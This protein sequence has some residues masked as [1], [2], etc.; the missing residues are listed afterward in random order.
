MPQIIP[1]AFGLAA[2]GLK[3]A[4]AWIVFGLSVVSGALIS[5]REQPQLGDVSDIGTDS[6]VNT[7]STQEPLRIIYGQLK[8]GGNDVYM[9][10]DGAN[11]QDLWIVQSLSE[12]ECEGVYAKEEVDQVYLDGK[13]YTDFGGNVT[14][15]FHSGTITQS[16]DTNL[17][18]ALTEWTDPL[19]NTCYMVWKLTNDKD[20]F[21]GLPSRQIELRG[22]KLYDFRSA[23]TA[24]SNNPVLAIYDYMTNTRYGMGVASAD[25]DTTSWTSAANYCDTKGWTLNM[26][27]KRNQP[28]QYVVDSMLLHFRY[29]L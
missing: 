26:V 3:G 27:I 24:Y 4:A 18:S 14:Y 13:I 21:Q 5:S 8:V 1:I 28:A 11:N 10:T 19:K 6:K 16:V 12:G 22:K 2:L 23:T 15:Y 29:A 9:G 7:A 17:N 20:Y 25:I